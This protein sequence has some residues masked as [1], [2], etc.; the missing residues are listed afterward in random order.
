MDSKLFSTPLPKAVQGVHLD[1]AFWGS[2]S[3]ND[4]ATYG[5]VEHRKPRWQEYKRQYQD[6]AAMERF[7]IDPTRPVPLGVTVTADPY[8]YPI[9]GYTTGYTV[10]LP[11][12]A[13]IVAAQRTPKSFN[14]PAIVGRG[15]GS[16]EMPPPPVPDSEESTGPGFDPANGPDWKYGPSSGMSQTADMVALAKKLQDIVQR[17]G[18]DPATAAQVLT[19]RAGRNIITPRTVVGSRNQGT[20]PP[21]QP[22]TADA[23]TNIA[24]PPPITTA[25]FL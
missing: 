15:D 2:E 11:P 1:G 24:I 7:G 25:G 5:Y 17:A 13:D 19:L 21:P 6:P 12:P 8:G 16:D 4:N 22:A 10:K 23:T 14:V 9:D 18:V 20:D 3:N